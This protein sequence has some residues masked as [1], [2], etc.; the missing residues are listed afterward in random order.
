[1][2][3]LE[4]HTYTRSEALSKFSDSL[5]LSGMD[6]WDLEIYMLR[7]NALP[8]AV[9]RAWYSD[10]IGFVQESFSGSKPVTVVNDFAN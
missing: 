1:M 7:I 4:G 10:D 5:R 6:D 9:M 3:I 8:Y 2:F